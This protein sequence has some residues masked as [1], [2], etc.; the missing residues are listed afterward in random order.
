MAN[1]SNNQKKVLLVAPVYMDLYKD[2]MTG[3]VSLGYD[4]TYYPDLRIPGDPFNKKLKDAKLSESDFMH[5]IDALWSDILQED[6]NK[7]IYDYLLVVDGLSVPPSLI[8]RLKKLNPKLVACNYLY[9]RIRGIYEV[10]R[11][12]A[13]FDRIFSFDLSDSEEYHLQFLPIYWVPVERP[14]KTEHEVFGFGGM[15]SYRLEV[16]RKIRKEVKEMAKSSFIK[17]YYFNDSLPLIFIKNLVKRALGRPG[18]TF[19]DFFSGMITNKSL[20]PEDFRKMI[21]SS[22]VVLDTNH[23]YQDGLTARF[24]WALGAEKKIITTNR[25]VR[26]YSFYSE[27]QIYILNE[28]PRSIRSFLDSDFEMDEVFRVRISAYRIDKWLNTILTGL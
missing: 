16:F 24:M 1:L 23:P 8:V 5:K 6:S 18:F 3:L 20:P 2:I 10:D 11:N 7:G 27:K 28:D 22:H 19:S 17:I 13:Y 26:D 9:D 25:S 4:V 14:L 15:D 21:L 12:F